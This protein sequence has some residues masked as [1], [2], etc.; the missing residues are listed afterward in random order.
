MSRLPQLV[1]RKSAEALIDTG[2]AF[3]LVT[4]IMVDRGSGP[5]SIQTT[6]GKTVWCNGMS[7]VRLVV[8][9]MPLTIQMIAINQMVEGVDMVLGNYT[10][11]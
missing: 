2:C 11:R 3:T 4:K 7:I 1:N 9:R 5:R 6:D 8:Y 10:T